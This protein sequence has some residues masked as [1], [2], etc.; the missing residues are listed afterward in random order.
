VLQAAIADDPTATWGSLLEPLTPTLPLEECAPLLTALSRLHAERLD[1]F[2]VCRLGH[3]PLFASLAGIGEADLHNL[4]LLIEYLQLPKRLALRVDQQREANA[5]CAAAA[6]RP[7][8]SRL[9]EAL[10]TAAALA[11]LRDD[12]VKAGG[13]MLSRL[14]IDERARVQAAFSAGLC[15]DAPP[16]RCR[17][18]AVGA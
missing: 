16:V 3:E 13:R 2:Q 4:M 8:G 14:S 11:P 5:A 17:L 18:S 1:V 12:A 15:G 10:G 7:E 9:K 6:A